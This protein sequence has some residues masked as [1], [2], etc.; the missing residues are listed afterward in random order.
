VTGVLSI[1][2]TTASRSPDGS[3]RTQ[4]GGDAFT[5]A[6][7]ARL[8]FRVRADHRKQDDPGS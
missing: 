2:E 4:F 1:G 5:T 3:A 8:D 7:L 6:H